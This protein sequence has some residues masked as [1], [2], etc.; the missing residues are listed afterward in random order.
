MLA[1]LCDHVAH[2]AR[3][4][5]PDDKGFA[6]RVHLVQRVERL[7]RVHGADHPQTLR[8]QAELDGP[9]APPALGYLLD[10][11]HEL[12]GR[13]GVTMDGLAPLSFATVDSWARLTDRA[14]L[15][16]EVDALLV[17]DGVRR[18]PPTEVTDG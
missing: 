12:Y 5:R 4:D 14:P 16:H 11:H 1:A 3:L 8:A 6:E 13:S 18:H 9:D 17:L 7:T 15:P 2:Q 10:W